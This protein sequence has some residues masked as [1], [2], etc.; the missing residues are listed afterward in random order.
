MRK[1]ERKAWQRDKVENAGND[2][3][4]EDYLKEVGFDPDVMRVQR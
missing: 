2:V 4:H 1:D 3:E